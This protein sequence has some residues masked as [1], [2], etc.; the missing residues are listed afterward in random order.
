MD[1]HLTFSEDGKSL[2]MVSENDG[3]LYTA[4]LVKG[5]L[6]DLWS[7]GDTWSRENT[8]TSAS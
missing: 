6:E 5:G 3:E 4:K 8:G 7:D 1:E 2:S